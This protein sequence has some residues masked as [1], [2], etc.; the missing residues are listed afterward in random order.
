M[1]HQIEMTVMGHTDVNTWGSLPGKRCQDR[2]EQVMNRLRRRQHHVRWHRS[3]EPALKD[4]GRALHRTLRHH[5]GIVLDKEWCEMR[6]NHIHACVHFLPDTALFY[7]VRGLD[8][9]TVG[10]G[11]EPVQ[12]SRWQ[13]ETKLVSLVLPVFREG[14][15]RFVLEMVAIIAAGRVTD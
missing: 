8:A 13:P 14:H 3:A 10:A 7:L 11:V 15:K 2:P 9:A 6:G 1:A 12:G 4:L 5:F